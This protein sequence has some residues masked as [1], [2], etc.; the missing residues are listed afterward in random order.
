MGKRKLINAGTELLSGY[1]KKTAPRASNLINPARSGGISRRLT[2]ATDEIVEATSKGINEAGEDMARKLRSSGGQEAVNEAVAKV[3]SKIGKRH[4][5]SPLSPEAVRDVTGNNLFGGIPTPSTDTMD[6]I[7]ELSGK[8]IHSGNGI[9]I[10]E[11]KGPVKPQPKMGP[12]GGPT[13]ANSMPKRSESPQLNK[14]NERNRAKSKTAEK[15]AKDGDKTIFGLTG[16]Q[17]LGTAVG[18]GLIF[19]MFNRGGQMT[20]SEL[21]GQSSPYGY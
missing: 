6:L 20:N 10:P 17:M 13:I 1:S 19:S 4:K 5:A 14:M 3:D 16:K 15:A 18:G 21:Y 7:H 2:S 12:V 11:P 9:N 8:G